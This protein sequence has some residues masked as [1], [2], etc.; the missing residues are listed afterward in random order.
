M[1]EMEHSDWFPERSILFCTARS[2]KSNFTCVQ[3]TAFDERSRLFVD[4]GQSVDRE[5]Q[6]S[7]DK[8][9][10]THQ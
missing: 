2:D 7:L 3:L 10:A 9:R 8:N 4:V 6:S 5:H 1:H